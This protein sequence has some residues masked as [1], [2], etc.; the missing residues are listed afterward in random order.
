MAD[1][2]FPSFNIGG[3]NNSAAVPKASASAMNAG[4][5]RAKSRD[6]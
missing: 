5:R 3:I 1:F 4:F 6:A 2:K